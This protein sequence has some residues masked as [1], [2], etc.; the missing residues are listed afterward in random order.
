MD[1]SNEVFIMQIMMPKL[2]KINEFIWKLGIDSNIYLITGKKNIIIDTGPKAYNKFIDMLLAKAFP[3]DKVDYVF[4]THLHHDHIGNFDMFS[5]ATFHASKTEIDS[6][7]KD[8]EG[9]ILDKGTWDR[10]KKANINLTPFPEMEGIEV[11]DTPG[12]TAG[13]VCFWMEKEKILFSGDTLF[14]TTHGRTDLPTG[15]EKQMQKT[16]VKLI[17]FNFKTLCPGHDY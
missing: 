6:L 1:I 10:F 13:S 16:L 12:H 8:S 15:D 14:N 9:T 17:N 2:E 4:F 5:N 7:K 3:L 11:I